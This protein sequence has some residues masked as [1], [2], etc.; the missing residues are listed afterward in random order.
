MDSIT[1]N[2]VIAVLFALLVI[3]LLTFLHQKYNPE[4]K[5][6]KKLLLLGTCVGAYSASATAS[7]LFS[8]ISP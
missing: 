7:S 1:L 3:H 2:V 8:Y 4:N 5:A 6:L